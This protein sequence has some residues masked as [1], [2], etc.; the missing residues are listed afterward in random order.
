MQKRFAKSR[1]IFAMTGT[2]FK[3]SLLMTSAFILFPLLLLF[4]GWKLY[5]RMMPRETIVQSAHVTLQRLEKQSQLVTTRAFVQIVV[6]QKSEAWYGNAE[7]LRI[8]P[9]TIHY[10][11]NLA[12]IDHAK[13]EFDAAKRV[14][15]IPLPEVKITAIDPDLSRAE[16]IRSLDAL[17]TQGGAGNELEKATEQMIRPELEKAGNNPEAINTAKQQAVA[18]V[19]MLLESV[20]NATGQRVEVHPYFQQEGKSD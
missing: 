4:T 7:V 11:V 10:A 14:L 9:A 13:M 18:S 17:R 6:R 15:Y 5:E 1:E 12:G 16:T 3:R 2:D 8:V 20:L 19:R